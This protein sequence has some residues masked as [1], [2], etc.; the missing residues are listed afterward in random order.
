MRWKQPAKHGLLA[1]ALGCTAIGA[2][3]TPSTTLAAP[4]PTSKAVYHQFQTYRT[5][6]VKSTES[7][8]KA[9]KYLMNHIDKVGPWQATLMTLQLE[10]MQNV[11]LADMDHRMYTEQFQQAISQAHEQLGYEQKLT[12][13]RLLKEIKDPNVKKLLQEASD[14]GFKLE[15][16]EGLYYPIIN[17]EIYQKFKPFVKA[18]IAAYINIMAT[19]SNQMTTSD[20]GII[21]SWNE[22]I[23]R[24]LEKEA[25]LNNFPNS[26]RTSAVKQGL[27]VDYLFYGSDNTPAYDWYTDE[28]IRTMD[29]EVKQAYEKTLAK[30]EPNTQSV[31]L[32]TMEKILLVLNQNTDELTPEVRAIIEPVQQQFARE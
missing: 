10:N 12:Y 8:V 25:F 22:L 14:L 5:E 15:T 2:I 13:S 19:E 4:V 29:P 21:I 32:D 11:K 24:A 1:M 26:N 20:G 31:L 17:Y 9:R 23:Q 16:S 6:A 3:L 28:E 27:F 7:L 30:R 18:D